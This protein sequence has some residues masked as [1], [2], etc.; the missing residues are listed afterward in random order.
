MPTVREVADYFLTLIDADAG[1]SLTN[2]KLQKLVYY[3]QGLHLAFYD[4]PLFGEQMEAWK[5]GPV[6]PDLYHAL[7][8]CGSDAVAPP[9]VVPD[10][11]DDEREL[12]GEVWTVFGQFSAWKLAE[13]THSEPPWK[14]AWAAR[15][16]GGDGVI[17]D[18]ALRAYFKTQIVA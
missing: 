16:L 6:V 2:L 9:V 8:G 7:K 13:L 15:E 14:E 11:S 18:D 12:I 1:D 5:H 3:A 10:L 17:T 4:R